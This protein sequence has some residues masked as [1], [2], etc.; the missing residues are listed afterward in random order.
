MSSS[1]DTFFTDDEYDSTRD[2]SCHTYLPKIHE[3]PLTITAEV[4]DPSGVKWVRLRY[5]SV[6]QT[7]DYQTIP[8][9]LAKNNHVYKAIVPAENIPFKWDFMYFIEVMDTNSNGKIY[10]DLEKETPYIVVKLQW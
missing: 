2:K 6:N 1:F 7:F 10:P 3:Q 8:M 4:K 9:L 5:R